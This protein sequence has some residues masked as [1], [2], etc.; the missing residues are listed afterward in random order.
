MTV[1][2]KHIIYENDCRRMFVGQTI[3]AV[4]YGELK[5]FL[6]EEGNNT[7]PAPYYKTRYPD[8]DTLDC[9]IYFKTDNQTIYIFWDNT[10]ICYGLQSKLLD[11]TETTNDYEQKW[12]VSPDIKWTHVIGQEIVD[13]KIIW[14]ETWTSDLDDS[15]KVYITYPQTFEIKTKN[16]KT[17]ILSASEFKGNEETE[18]YPF[19]DNILGKTTTNNKMT[20]IQWF[21]VLPFD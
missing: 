3:R 16:G 14:E 1:T 19:M 6:D 18:I 11:L 8:I 7:N 21:F 10:F 15:N 5:Y 2:N 20:R 12:D 17:I 13:F 9:S 4:M